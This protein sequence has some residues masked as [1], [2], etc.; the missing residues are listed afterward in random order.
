M[1]AIEKIRKLVEEECR[2][3]SNIFGDEIWAYHILSVVKYAT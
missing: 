3:D 1:N 2:K